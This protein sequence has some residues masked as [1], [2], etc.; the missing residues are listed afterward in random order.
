MNYLQDINYNSIL[1]HIKHNY[2][3]PE[4]ILIIFS[5]YIKHNNMSNN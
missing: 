2:S 3:V 4:Q 1:E 5:E